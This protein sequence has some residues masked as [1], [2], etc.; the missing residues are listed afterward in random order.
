MQLGNFSLCTTPG[1]GTVKATAFAATSG[2]ASRFGAAKQVRSDLGLVPRE[3]SS[4]TSLSE[5][6]DT[7]VRRSGEE[8]ARR[9]VAASE[10]RYKTLVGFTSERV[11]VYTR[12]RSTTCLPVRFRLIAEVLRCVTPGDS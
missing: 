6:Q 11:S 5:I 8:N 1:A 3:L 4:E 7:C 9:R 2:I 12:P 10:S